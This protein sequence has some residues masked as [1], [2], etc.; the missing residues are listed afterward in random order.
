MSLSPANHESPE[1]RLHSQSLLI[2][3]LVLFNRVGYETYYDPP[4]PIDIHRFTPCEND[5]GHH[6]DDLNRFLI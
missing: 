4:D 6:L 1:E 3:C 2:L 5:G